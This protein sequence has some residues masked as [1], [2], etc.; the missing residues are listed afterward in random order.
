MRLIALLFKKIYVLKMASL[1]KINFWML[2]PESEA[3]NMEKEKGQRQ[4]SKLQ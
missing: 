4:I 1:M 2:Q 3:R